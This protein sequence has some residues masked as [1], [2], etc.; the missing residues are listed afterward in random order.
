VQ[1]QPKQHFQEQSTPTAAHLS[2]Q[3][4]PSTSETVPDDFLVNS[5]LLGMCESQIF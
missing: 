3:C 5:L 1:D 2:A 4:L